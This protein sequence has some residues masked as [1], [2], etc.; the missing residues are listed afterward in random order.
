VLLSACRK[1]ALPVL[2]GFVSAAAV[3][4]EQKETPRPYGMNFVLPVELGE[5][6]VNRLLRSA[7]DSERL[8][9]QV[10]KT[11]LSGGPYSPHLSE[12]LVSE[13]NHLAAAGQ[14][15][16]AAR[17]LRRAVHITRINDGL[18]SSRQL[19][20]LAQLD[21]SYLATADWQHLDDVREYRY[22]LQR[23]FHQPLSN[24]G[25]QATLSYLDWQRKRW[26]LELEEP[27]NR[28]FYQNFQQLENLREDLHEKGRATDP[29]MMEVVMMQMQYYYLL[30]ELE[31]SVPEQIVNGVSRGLAEDP[32][33]QLNMEERQLHLLKS[34]AYSRGRKRLEQLQ[35]DIRD[36]ATV[37]VLARLRR[38]RGDW[39]IW[40]GRYRRAAE[41]YRE[42]WQLLSTA[43]ASDLQQ[44][45]FAEPQELPASGAFVLGPEQVLKEEDYVPLRAS[46]WVTRRGQPRDLVVTDLAGEETSGVHRLRR[47]L[48]K[49]RFR[50]VVLAGD[51][52]DSGL[53]TREYRATQ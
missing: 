19:P 40:F 26:L 39:D 48:R 46:L 44:E 17:S 42:S 47:W 23:R 11:E 31:F 50:P 13:A 52:V 41:H 14:H 9:E 51:T 27:D 16:N 32:S 36:T 49:S 15:A 35:E 43:G 34:A 45:W 33:Q 30:Q 25:V 7:P 21:Q 22:H 28:R 24:E 6:S 12:A 20:L 53:I 29:V 10:L 4:L 8:R 2:L 3:A 5:H 38:E 37:E 18:N 1:C